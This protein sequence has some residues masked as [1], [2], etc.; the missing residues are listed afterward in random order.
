MCLSWQELFDMDMKDDG[1]AEQWSGD[2]MWSSGPQPSSQGVYSLLLKFGKTLGSSREA[3]LG[4]SRGKGLCCV[5]RAEEQS[6]LAFIPA[7]LSL[8]KWQHL[9]SMV[10]LL[11][12]PLCDTLR[13][14]WQ[15]NFP[16]GWLLS[17]SLNGG[18]KFI[19]VKLL[20]CW[21]SRW[22]VGAVRYIR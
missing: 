19:F 16:L 3:G 21:P 4:E 5:W 18:V 8:W 11:L 22:W 9:V 6:L 2:A 7:E 20:Y 12:G 14:W 10:A 13:S 17:S 15:C 1:S